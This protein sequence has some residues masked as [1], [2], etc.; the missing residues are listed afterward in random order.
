MRKLNNGIRSLVDDMLA[1]YVAAFGDLVARHPS[2]PRV[3]VRVRPKAAGHVGLAIGNGSGHEPIAVGWVGEG[4]LDANAVGDVFS[5]PPPGMVADAIAAADT[6]AGVVL[7]VSRHAGDVLNGRMGAELAEDAGH[8]VF[9]L[10][11][12]DDMATA[13][14]EHRGERRGAPGTT[15]VYKVLGAAAEEGMSLDDLGALGGRLLAGTSTLSVTIAPGTSP[16]TG[17]PT[18]AVPDGEVLL[19]SGVHGEGGSGTLPLTTADE[20]VDSLAT[21]LL[22]DL[23]PGED[24]AVL[25][26]VNG[27]G[28]TT[29]S[30]LLVVHGAFDRRLRAERLEPYHP[31][32]GSLVTTQ[33]TAGFSL[34]IARTDVDIR[35]L[36]TAPCRAPYFPQP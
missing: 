5:A 35:R 34:S 18:A 33:D 3:V 24:P 8:R 9:V 30:E 4:L 15:F 13:P 28:A 21:R 12:G 36:W 10:E 2:N 1:G 19:G 27:F 29:L 23:A 20:L 25:T 26:L 6:G 22:D 17:E 31:L 7:L 11:M 14:P 32:V 16:L